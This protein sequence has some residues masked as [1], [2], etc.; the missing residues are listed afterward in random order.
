MVGRMGPPDTV[1]CSALGLTFSSPVGLGAGLDVNA[2]APAAFAHFGFGFLEVGPVTLNA[3]QPLEKVVRDVEHQAICYPAVTANH[4]ASHLAGRLRKIGALRVPLGIRL[5]YAP[6]L[7]AVQAAHE[8]QQLIE[9]LAPYASFFVLDCQDALID[10]VWNAWNTSQ[11]AEHLASVS[12]V[13]ADKASS[14]PILINLRADL[15]AQT[16][17]Q[18]TQTALDRGIC[19]VVV[20]GG[21]LTDSGQRL[22][23][24]PTREV[25]LRAVR[26][27]RATFGDQVTIIGS[28][29]IQQP[30]DALD[31]LDAGATLIEL[32][33]GFVYSGPGLPKRI[34]EAIG[35]GYCRT[36]SPHPL[37]R[38]TVEG[39]EGSQPNMTP[40]PVGESVGD[41]RGHSLLESSWFWIALLGIGLTV[42]G[43]VVWIVAITRTVLPYD[44]TFVGLTRAQLIAINPRLLPFM[45]HD[46]VTL[47]GTMLATGI[48]YIGLALGGI[49]HGSR[50]ARDAV[51]ISALSGFASFFLFLGFGYFDPIHALL[52]AG[53]L[54]LFLF[55][56]RARLSRWSPVVPPNRTN[57]RR[58]LTGQWGQFI[59]VT[60]GFGLVLSGLAIINVGVAHVFVPE[61]LKFLGTTAEALNAANARL[62]PLIAHDRV[63][64]GGNLISVGLAVLL[65]SL[66]CFRQ[67][68]RWVWWTLA[69]AGSAGFLG[70]ISIHLAVGYIDLWHLFPA[71]L[72]I[73]LFVIGLAWSFVYLNFRESAE[74]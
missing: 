63:G 49:R 44:E 68:E 31:F 74:Q 32:H 24:A 64:F 45:E 48:L 30:Q 26:S 14:R 46:R 60:I 72:A 19:G 36:K 4:G 29:G 65:L 61:D 33:S 53:L 38:G 51:S 59:F 69:L 5:G 70:A 25:S 58:W 41:T 27:L 67:G 10:G 56:V 21:I 73:V 3:I 18:L 15:E 17:Q 55:S 20:G 11:W 23:G 50:W 7:D 39:R 8:R 62:L 13:Q 34:N 47:A 12:E 66:W 22:V 9:Q 35:Y 43:I 16:L 37:S 54:P 6:G 57:N 40:S 28:G 1:R 71:L 42:S 52:T 2:V